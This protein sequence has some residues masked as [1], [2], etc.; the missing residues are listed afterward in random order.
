[1]SVSVT[2][3]GTTPHGH[4]VDWITLTN[5][6]GA[7]VSFINFGAH[8]VSIKVPDRKGSLGDVALGMDSLPEYIATGNGY[9][10]ATIGRYANRIAGASFMMNGQEYKLYANN[11]AN[12][13]HGGRKGFDKRLWSFETASTAGEDSITMHYISPDMEEG[14]PGQ[15]RVTVTFRWD[16]ACRLRIDY[17]AVADKDTIV[18]L[19][20]HSYFNLGP[21]HDIKSHSLQI[22]GDKVI[23]AGEDLIPTGMM[24]PVENTP[25][26]LR[27][28]KR[29]GEVLTR[30]DDPMFV[31]AKGFDIG[32]VL[33]GRDLR[34]V[35]KL[36]DSGSGRMM[37][38]LTDQ[39]G[40]QCYSGQGFDC[41]GRGG[42]HYGPYAGIALE[43]QQHPDTVHQP[44]FGD[45]TL[46]AG[47]VYRTST[48]YAFSIE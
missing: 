4:L 17:S 40:V 35:A 38:V 8:I 42:V 31:A 18:N 20:N 13:L 32:Y 21:D 3:F 26:D 15:L 23:A 6:I 11:G 10:G 27:Q 44:G 12:T 47:Q 45:T 9:M 39:P 41:Q 19:T 36:H 22:L 28:P 33:P 16:D 46:R 2:F 29:L 5:T 34:E 43:T 48:V 30:S 25:Y 14:Y 7:S 37:K 1:M 24:V